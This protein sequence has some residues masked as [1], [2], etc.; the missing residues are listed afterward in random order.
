ME[1]QR[2]PLRLPPQHCVH[3]A[4]SKQE[5]GESQSLSDKSTWSWASLGGGRGG[6]R[7]A[8]LLTLC[9]LQGQRNISC[10][11]GFSGTLYERTIIPI[12]L[13]LFSEQYYTKHPSQT[14][15]IRDRCHL[16]PP[17]LGQLHK[18]GLLDN[19]SSCPHGPAL[20]PGY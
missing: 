6:G 20:E 8:G 9:N 19:M 18:K 15:A 12:T 17:H 16:T 7:S 13:F 4:R 10:S 11:W 3:K 5:Q 14:C 1:T 2:S